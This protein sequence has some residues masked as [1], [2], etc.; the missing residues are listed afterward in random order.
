MAEAL[1]TKYRPKD[2]DS[3]YGQDSIKKILQKQI[4]TGD[5]RNAYAFVG[6][7]GC[8][9]TSLARLFANKLNRG[10][11]HPIEIDAASNSGVDNVREIISMASERAIDCEYKVIICDEAH[12]FSSSA[13]QAFL[14][15]IEEPPAYT[16]FIFCTTESKKIPVTIMNRVQ[17][18][19]FNRI[20]TNLI[21]ERLI[22]TKIAITKS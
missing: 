19:N 12:S 2:W 21:K 9:K 20:K 16:I 3:V 4:E 14:K 10:K 17:R 7:S 1:H 6:S 22:L 11:G 18:L 5:I 15:C 13:W 8:G